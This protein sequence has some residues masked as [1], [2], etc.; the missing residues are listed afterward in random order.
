MRLGRRTCQQDFI[1]QTGRNGH[2]TEDKCDGRRIGVVETRRD[3]SATPRACRRLATDDACWTAASGRHSGLL[4]HWLVT[5]PNLHAAIWTAAI[6]VSAALHQ[7]LSYGRR[8]ESH[9][10][11]VSMRKQ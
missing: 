5:F 11:V 9:L 3:G 7:V 10:M 2:Q 4:Q 6:D 1:L 8:I